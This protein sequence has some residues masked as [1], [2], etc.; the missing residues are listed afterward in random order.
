MGALTV[1]AEGFFK[2][3]SRQSN[4][5]LFGV[6]YSPHTVGPQVSVKISIYAAPE[7]VSLIGE[8][9]NRSKTRRCLWW[10]RIRLWTCE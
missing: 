4:A 1:A 7:G 10:L 2:R 8:I 9:S 5:A 3:A 6:N